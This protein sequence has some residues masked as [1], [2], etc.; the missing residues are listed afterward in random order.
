[1]LCLHSS[2]VARSPFPQW[3][4]CIAGICSRSTGVIS[5]EC[6]AQKHSMH[7]WAVQLEAHMVTPHARLSKSR[8]WDW[9]LV[10]ATHMSSAL[11]VCAAA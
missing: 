4:M 10:S 5:A 6:T 8:H 1:M 3:V 2:I 9:L 7:R 11:P